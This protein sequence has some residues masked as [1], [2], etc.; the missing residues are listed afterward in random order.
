MIRLTVFS[1]YANYFYGTSVIFS[2]SI[3]T[4]REHF[5]ICIGHDQQTYVIG[6]DCVLVTWLIGNIN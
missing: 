1:V 4:Y 6:I 5:T 3:I 2:N